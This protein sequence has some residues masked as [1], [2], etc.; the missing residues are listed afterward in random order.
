[1]LIASLALERF[2]NYETL[3]LAVSPRI[4]VFYGMNGQG[5]TNLLEAIYLCTCAR[6]HRTARDA[7]LIQFGA[8]GYA[9]ELDFVSQG[10]YQEQLRIEYKGG[11]R[12]QRKRQV[13]HD[14]VPLPRIQ[15][16]MGLFQSV[17][18][19]PEDLNLLKLGPA[20]R[21]RFL[22]LLIAQVDRRYFVELQRLARLLAQRNRILKLKQTPEAL[23]LLLDTWD[24][25][26]AEATAYLLLSRYGVCLQL[27]E[28]AAQAYADISEGRERFKMRYHSL[29]QRELEQVWLNEVE[30]RLSPEESGQGG[31]IRPPVE[32][33]TA[34][35]QLI[36]ARFFKSR[37]EDLFKGS[38]QLGAHRDDLY[39]YMDDKLA[40]SVA[41]QGQTRSMVLA[42]K[43][44]ELAWLEQQTG[45]RPVL[46]LDDVM[47]ELDPARR[48]ALLRA[49]DHAQVFVTCTE[50]EQAEQFWSAT[51]QAEIQYFRVTQGA[52]FPEQTEG[53]TA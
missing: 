43:L 13:F 42:L 47:S 8:S 15:D 40:K 4:N 37:K 21:R 20:E 5:K 46:L 35:S 6:S 28:Q 44:A 30:P 48:Q 18:F 32:A 25:Q 1:M 45:Q 39:L 24:Q 9:V 12:G 10:R 50:R 33:V 34:L 22:D 53:E 49:L 31:R 51:H 36:E 41:S 23:D 29:F 7:D 3:R 11:A 2:R 38:T 16:L 14:G 52:V 17:I 26:L 19:A 27:S